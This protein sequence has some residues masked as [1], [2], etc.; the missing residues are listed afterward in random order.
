MNY[1]L[2]IPR[3][4]GRFYIGFVKIVFKA[5]GVPHCFWLA[6]PEEAYTDF[7]LLKTH[8]WLLFK[9]CRIVSG[10]RCLKKHMNT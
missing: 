7:G 9:V 2:G 5:A 1:E 3:E 4:F 6:M 10:Q 8:E